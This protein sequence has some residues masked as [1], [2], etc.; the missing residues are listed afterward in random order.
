MTDASKKYLLWGFAGLWAV[1]LAFR[2]MSSQEPQEVPLKF[3]SR[4][5]NAKGNKSVAT[6]GL[7]VKSLHVS[8]EETVAMPKRNI[9]AAGHAA[10]VV[11]GPTPPVVAKRKKAAPPPIE[12]AEVQA[13]PPP[14]GPTPEELAEKAAREQQEL[15]L[16]QL[17]EQMGQYRYIGFV[18]QDGDRKAFL[19]KGHEIYI[20]RQGD[21]LDGKFVVATVE[22]ASVKIREADS[23]LETT[24]QLKKDGTGE[25]S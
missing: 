2:F 10:L 3:T 7:Q 9:F 17:K 6:V 15:K 8:T 1:L 13:P 18:T 22:A 12:V 4:G 21:K 19:G 24:I 20:I 14:P 5:Q 11:E 25:S 23:A 16:K